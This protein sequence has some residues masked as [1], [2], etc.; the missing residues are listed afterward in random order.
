MRRIHTVQQFGCG[1][2]QR[3][4][5]I[6]IEGL[7]AVGYHGDAGRTRAGVDDDVFDFIT[8]ARELAVE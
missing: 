1:P 8:R 3:C 4:D 7:V 2:R 5:R 6:K